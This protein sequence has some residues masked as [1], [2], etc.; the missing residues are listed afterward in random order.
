MPLAVELTAAE[1]NEPMVWDDGRWHLA[2]F[3]GRCDRLG[4]FLSE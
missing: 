2:S 3:T 1:D 4:E